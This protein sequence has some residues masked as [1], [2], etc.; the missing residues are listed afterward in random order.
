MKKAW[1]KSL[2]EAVFSIESRIES[3]DEEQDGTRAAPRPG[4]HIALTLPSALPHCRRGL[5]R[6]RGGTA[7]TDGRTLVKAEQQAVATRLGDDA[8]SWTRIPERARL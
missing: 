5:A 6:R 2:K 4:P 1:I 7:A 3:L 8:T